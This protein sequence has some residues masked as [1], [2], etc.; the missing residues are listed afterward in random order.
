MANSEDGIQR[1]L[2][3][4]QAAQTVIQAARTAKSKKIKQAQQEAEKEIAQY[5]AQREDA[6]KKLMEA[7][8]DD[9]AGRLA[10][11]EAETAK[12]VGELEKSVSSKKSE[13]SQCILDWVTKVY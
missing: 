5:K 10:K 6:Y 13:V 12:S 3:A 1:L 7:G 4:E 9:A 8:V 2:A 11:L